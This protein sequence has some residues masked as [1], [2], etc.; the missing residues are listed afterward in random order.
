MHSKNIR[1]FT[2]HSVSIRLDDGD[3]I[4]LPS[5]GV[6]RVDQITRAI[7]LVDTDKDNLTIEIAVPSY[8]EVFG[9]PAQQDGVLLIVSNFVA[10]AAL[11]RDDLVYPDSGPSAE[12]DDKGQ[13][14]AVRRLLRPAA[15]LNDGSASRAAANAWVKAMRSMGADQIRGPVHSGRHQGHDCP[16]GESIPLFAVGPHGPVG[17][18]I[19]DTDQC[20]IAPHLV[21][22]RDVLHPQGAWQPRSGEGWRGIV[23][24]EPAVGVF[25]SVESA[26]SRLGIAVDKLVDAGWQRG[27]IV[28]LRDGGREAMTQARVQFAQPR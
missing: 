1:N 24:G 2:P 3:K 23:D 25:V 28:A 26:A 6:A 14:V 11:D 10:I 27:S 5:E 9:L 18:I 22:W 12:R 7:G 4:T 17:S 13:V 21:C 8:G 15:T 16:P 20:P 19:V